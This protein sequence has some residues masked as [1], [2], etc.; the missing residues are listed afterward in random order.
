MAD[1]E[2]DAEINLEAELNLVRVLIRR[3]LEKTE[4]ENG[5]EANIRS[6]TAISAATSRMASILRTMHFLRSNGK[7]GG[8]PNEMDECL[9]CMDEEENQ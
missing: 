4:G 1:L 2:I 7:D 9:R 3:V 5:L 6:M 8:Q